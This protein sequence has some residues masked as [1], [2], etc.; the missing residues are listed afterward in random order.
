[1]KALMEIKELG[2]GGCWLSY[3]PIHADNRGNFREWFRADGIENTIGRGFEVRQANL[4]VSSKNTIRG[5]H[6]SKAK[7]GQ[8]KWV[9]CASGSI[10]D[11]VVDIRPTSLTF[12]KWIAIEL[13][14][15]SGQSLFISEGLGHGFLS[16]AESSVVVY[17]LN[18]QYKPE[19]EFG[20]HPLDNDL[21]ISWPTNN[22]IISKKDAAA[23]GFNTIFRNIESS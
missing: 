10:W 11:V 4:S 8:G 9:T 12:G 17:L 1:M 20:I 2:I 21:A 3:S 14:A 7:S 22:P 13:S 6:F 23:P 15:D 18:S 5:I 16:L 19:E